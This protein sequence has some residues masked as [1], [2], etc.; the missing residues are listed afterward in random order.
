MAGKIYYIEKLSYPQ[1]DALDRNKTIFLIA[2]SPLEEHG[3]HLPIGVDAFNA[4]FFVKLAAEIITEKHSE[5]DAVL[6]P[7]LPVGTQVY[8]HIGS[9]YVKPATVYD[10][11]YNTGR[12]IAIYGFKYIFAFSAHGTPKQ[13]VAVEAACRKVSKKRRT[14][15]L[16]LTGAIAMEFLN[17]KMYDEIAKKLDK[18]FTDEEKHLLKYDF[19]AGWWETAMMLRY[20]PGLVNDSYKSLKPYLK[21]FMSKKVITPNEKWQGYFGSP[22]KADPEFAEASIEVFSRKASELISRFLDGEDITGEATSPFF[23]YPF[24]HPFFKRNIAIGICIFIFVVMVLLLVKA[25]Y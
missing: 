25:Y 3:P 13:M 14:K 24:F 8:K 18:T 4:D 7:L 23:R 21:D 6:F 16:S 1:I 9:F 2:I 17:G 10:L 11:V 15:M 5:F 12:S 22:A 20:Y 19:H